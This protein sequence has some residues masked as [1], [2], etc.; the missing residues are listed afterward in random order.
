MLD[1]VN[2][3]V[4]ATRLL[5]ELAAQVAAHEILF[6]RHEGSGLLAA[7]RDALREHAARV[8]TSQ[9]SQ[10]ERYLEP[11]FG[12]PDADTTIPT[13]SITTTTPPTPPPAAPPTAPP[14]A[15]P[16]APPYSLPQDDHRFL[17][18]GVMAVVSNRVL[19]SAALVSSTR[20][21]DPITDPITYPR[22]EPTSEQGQQQ[23]FDVAAQ[24]FLKTPSVLL[25]D[26]IDRADEASAYLLAH[27]LESGAL[28]ASLVVLTG[29]CAQLPEVLSK[30]L[31]E[32]DFAAQVIPLAPLTDVA[33]QRWLPLRLGAPLEAN[34]ERYLLRH[35]GGNPRFTEELL[36]SLLRTQQISRYESVW[37][38]DRQ[39]SHVPRSLQDV[40]RQRLSHLPLRTLATLAAASTLGDEIDVT[41]LESLCQHYPPAKH[42]PT[43]LTRNIGRDDFNDSNDPD[44]ADDLNDSND[45]DDADDLNESDDLDNADDLNKSDDLNDLDDADDLNDSNDPDDAD[46]LNE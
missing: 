29:R 20:V 42:A 12:T 22:A 27:L 28:R 18:A 34:L 16:T 26:D 33:M 4:G 35:G 10:L 41:V 1:K 11:L 39:V 14:A 13:T 6:V 38:W 9:Y 37:R 3:G 32:H 24:L 44:D 31:F 17:T 7:W 21:Y 25:V 8:D 30:V 2:A 19:H 15:P 46:D 45:L 43:V 40:F 36:L 23:L 5:H